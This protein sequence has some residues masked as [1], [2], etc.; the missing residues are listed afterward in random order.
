VAKRDELGTS[1]NPLLGCTRRG[2]S[3]RLPTRLLNWCTSLVGLAL[4]A[5]RGGQL[6]SNRAVGIPVAVR[7]SLAFTALGGGL[8]LSGTCG[9]TLTGAAYCWRVSL[10]TSTLPT[11][12][13]D[14]LSLTAL[15]VGSNQICGLVSNGQAYCR[16]VRLGDVLAPVG[17]GLNFA[18]ISAGDGYVCGVVAGGAAYC[19]GDNSFGQLGNGSTTDSATPSAVTGPLIFASVS[20]GG[21][22]TCGVTTAGVAY[23]WGWNDRGQLGDGSTTNR[24]IPSPVAGGLTF[25]TIAVGGTHTCGI[26]GDG[27]TYCWGEDRADQLGLGTASGAQ[28]C[29]VPGVP[30]AYPADTVPCRTQPALVSGSPHFVA[31]STGGA[32][33]CALTG[34]GTAFCWGLNYYGQLGDG[35][36]GQSSIPVEVTG[37]LHFSFIA[38]G[39]DHTCGLTTNGLAFCW[40]GFFC[41]NGPGGKYQACDLLPLA[42]KSTSPTSRP[43]GGWW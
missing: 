28:V 40:G 16:G 8:N 15:T 9:L 5:C 20:A 29:V 4:A 31:L 24:S 35:S 1:D 34:S 26:A 32:H 36:S 18:T 14:S 38:S 21:G 41:G 11:P 25:T 10:D 2:G 22:H 27:G 43:D 33:T 23:C 39:D 17:V 3:S 42:H 19:W 37:G 7:G 13:S 12:V 30:G 6:M